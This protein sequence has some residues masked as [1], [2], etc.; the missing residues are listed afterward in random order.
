MSAAFS[1]YLLLVTRNCSAA[2]SCPVRDALSSRVAS[3]HLRY[4]SPTSTAICAS[5]SCAPLR[6]CSSVFENREFEQSNHDCGRGSKRW[7]GRTEF[8]ALMI[9]SEPRLKSANHPRERNGALLTSAHRSVP[10]TV[11]DTA[12]IV[13]DRDLSPIE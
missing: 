2:A 8:L 6:A 7:L 12:D 1:W 9:Q 11:L 5:A 13:R 10:K 4:F 3:C